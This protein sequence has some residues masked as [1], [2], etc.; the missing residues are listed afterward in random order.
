MTGR[1]SEQELIADVFFSMWKNAR[2][3][4][5][6][7]GNLRTYIAAIARN[8]TV[9]VMKKNRHWIQTYLR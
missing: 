7:C 2:H 6:S 5:A 8:K 4:D 9:D 1:H 3:I